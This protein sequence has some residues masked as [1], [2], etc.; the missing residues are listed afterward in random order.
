MRD[1]TNNNFGLLIAYV[2]P[3]LTALWGAAHFSPTLRFWLAASPSE[4]PTVGG[5][6]YVTLGSVAA[7]MTVSTVRWLIVDVACSRFSD[8]DVMRV[9]EAHLGKERLDDEAS[10]AA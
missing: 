6:L 4:L 5:F 2:L 8:P 3:G 7:G 1:V 10:E 9:S